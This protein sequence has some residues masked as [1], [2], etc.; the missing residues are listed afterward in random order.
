MAVPRLGVELELQLPASTTATAI[1]DPSRVCDPHH[2]L[3]QCWI[4]NQVSKARDPTIILMDPHRVL[5]LLSHSGNFW[6]DVF[7]VQHC[8]T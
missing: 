2:S 1:Q 6:E 5:N 4:L 7:Y 8:T 3:W